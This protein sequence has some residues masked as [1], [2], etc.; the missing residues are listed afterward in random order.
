VNIKTTGLTGAVAAALLLSATQVSAESI[1]VQVSGMFTEYRFLGVG[2]PLVGRDPGDPS[3]WDQNPPASDIQF[4]I[5]GEL[6][7]DGGIVTAATLVAGPVTQ[8]FAGTGGVD[9]TEGVFEGLVYTISGTN[10]V[11]APGTG[12]GVKGTCTALGGN[13]N[14]ACTNA[15]TAWQTEANSRLT[16]WN[17]IPEGYTVSDLFGGSNIFNFVLTAQNGVSWDVG[18]TEVG[19]SIVAQMF[20]NEPNAFPSFNAA[21]AGQLQLTVVPVPA[22]VW[23][24][25]SALGLIGFIRRRA[26]A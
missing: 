20:R 1:T 23:L 8:R 22:A 16:N 6:T 9:P 26:V 19:N 15:L 12:A 4:S 10:L 21:F 2:V 24:F 18:G 17:G 5:S 14:V 13:V 7:I 11:Q 3:T 25:A